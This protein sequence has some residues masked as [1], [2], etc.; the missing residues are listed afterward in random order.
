MLR[1]LWPANIGQYRAA[2]G[3]ARD[4]NVRVFSTTLESIAEQCIV[5]Q[6]NTRTS[7][8]TRKRGLFLRGSGERNVAIVFYGFVKSVDAEGTGD[9][10]G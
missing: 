9:W 10:Q 2:D 8:I 3:I 7:D 5:D 4:E 6:I 1:D